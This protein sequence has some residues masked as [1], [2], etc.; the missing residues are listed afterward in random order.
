MTMALI[1]V[2]IF[3][4]WRRWLLQTVA[5]NR[6][7]LEHLH[8]A[9]PISRGLI[10]YRDF[11]EHHTPGFWFMLA[12]LYRWYPVE[13]NPDTAVAFIIMARQASWFSRTMIC[14]SGYRPMFGP[15]C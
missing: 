5:I 2:A 14:S 6:D 10:T 7:E 4:L 8:D 1:L 13:Q 12:P 11:F 15:R 9:W 3:Y